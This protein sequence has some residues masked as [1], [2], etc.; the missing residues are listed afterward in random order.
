MSLL[1][2]NRD[3]A[4]TAMI[5]LRRNGGFT[6]DEKGESAG[7]DLWAV[8]IPGCERVCPAKPS[9]DVVK[10]YLDE[11]PL[12]G[13]DYFGGWYYK[14]ANV[15]FLDHTELWGQRRVAIQQAIAHKQDAI[16]N[17][18][19]KETYTIPAEDAPEVD[20]GI[21]EGALR[22]LREKL[23]ED[24]P[25]DTPILDELKTLRARFSPGAV[26]DHKGGR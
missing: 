3:L 10:A 22:K 4:I 15:T 20:P 9:L 1:K 19:T 16:Y 21:V 18:L 13:V 26:L 17:L 7:G 12:T 14:E 8:S 23:A 24:T 2:S 11:F 25:H 5:L 6:I